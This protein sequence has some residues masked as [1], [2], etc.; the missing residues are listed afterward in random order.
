MLDGNTLT[1]AVLQRAAKLSSATVHEAAGKAGAL[2]SVLKPIAAHARLA[3]RAFPVSCPPGDNLWLHRAI[4]AAA[5]GDV[6]VVDV[7][8]GSE[9]GYWGEVMAL[10]AQTR[11][12][13]GLVITGGVRDSVRLA[14]MGFPVFSKSICIRGTGKNP[15]AS[16]K[17]GEPV[18]IGEVLI[19]KGD[20][21]LGDADGLVVIA[22]TQAAQ[23]I[24]AAEARD[25]AERSIFVEIRSGRSTIDIYNLPT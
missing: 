22:R 12:I 13:A 25:E 1:D 11:G 21:V 18:T 23:V 9:C 2:P 15:E 20:L 17:L 10:A 3:G 24:A 16:G 7:S 5:P 8:G 19:R 14:E 6:L 4:Y